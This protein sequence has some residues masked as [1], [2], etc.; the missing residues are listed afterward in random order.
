VHWLL[1]DLEWEL[2]N[3]AGLITLWLN[4]DQGPVSLQISAGEDGSSLALAFQL[5]R[6]GERLA[7]SGTVPPIAGWVSPTY[8]LRLPALSLSVQVQ[9]SLPLRLVSEWRLPC[10]SS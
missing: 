4:T 7:G 2:E 9:G 8:G 3:E 6:V 5:A 1:P 10:T